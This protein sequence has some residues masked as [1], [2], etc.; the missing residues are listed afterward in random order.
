MQ[1]CTPCAPFFV[2]HQYKKAIQQSFLISERGAGVKPLRGDEF[3][4][5]TTDVR[6]LYLIQKVFGHMHKD[7]EHHN[8]PTL[9]RPTL[10]YSPRILMNVNLESL[11]V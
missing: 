10:M 11:E 4:L 9:G 2:L 1:D 7:S 3:P 5:F 8:I 6:T